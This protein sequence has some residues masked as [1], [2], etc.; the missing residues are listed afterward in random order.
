MLARRF[1]QFTLPSRR[2]T[3]IVLACVVLLAGALLVWAAPTLLWAYNVQQAGALMERGLAWPEPRLS[4]S[5]PRQTDRAALDAALGHLAAA[6]AWRPDDAHAHRMAGEVYLAQGEWR[7][8]VEAYSQAHALAP[9][10][11]MIA[12]ETGLAYDQLARAMEAAPRVSLM[13]QFA[14]GGV[15]A[16]G[17]LVRSLFCNDTG[18][19]SC[20]FG[21]TQYTLPFAETGEPQA[22]LPV[23]FLHSPAQLKQ[24]VMIPSDT[25]ILDFVAGLDPVVHQSSDG[26]TLRVLVEDAAG[27]ATPV[28]E[29]AVNHDLAARGWIRGDA[30][31]SRWAGQELTL[32]LE[33]GAGPA[34][35]TTDDWFGWGNI[36]LTAPGASGV[37]ISDLRADM[38]QA[39]HD[40]G[41]S[42]WT[43]QQRGKEARNAGRPDEA[44]AWFRRSDIMDMKIESR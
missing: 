4:D 5:I 3:L 14:H 8:A 20:Y 22:T 42:W 15:E 26:A 29:R 32:V 41:F 35:D 2:A 31:L 19:A 23:L 24:R 38:Q 1:N 37:A 36:A 39:W 12:W 33:T 44:Q 40:G 7:R 17:V 16:P 28:Y 9:D 27:H 13:E 18:A 10:N 43:F 34:G 6:T 21:R 25:P 30:D 11:P